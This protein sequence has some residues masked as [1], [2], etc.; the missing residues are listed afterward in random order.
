MR[1]TVRTA[2]GALAAAVVAAASAPAA[3]EALLDGTTPM[4]C[5]A[6]RTAVCQREGECV[7]GSAESVNLPVLWRVDVASKSV[8]SLSR[9]EERA[10]TVLSAQVHAEAIVVQGAENGLGWSLSVD[11]S[12]GAMVLAGGREQGFIAFGTCAAS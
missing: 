6:T 10:S 7:Q 8:D 9:G 3:A 1:G 11:R 2:A 4:I 12:T 5:A